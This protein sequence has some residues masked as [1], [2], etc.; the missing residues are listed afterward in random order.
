MQEIAEYP[1][2]NCYIPSSGMC[3]IKCINYFTKK[4]YTEQFLTFKRS[5]QRRSIVM[6]AARIQPFCKRYNINMG[7]FDGTRINPRSITR[8]NPALFTYEN[9]FCLI[10]KSSNISFDQVIEN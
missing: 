8:R 7:C 10:W 4:D 2:Q 5:K 1:R 6:T 9:H 3:F